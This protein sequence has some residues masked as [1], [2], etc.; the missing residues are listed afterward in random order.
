MINLLLGQPGGGKSYE[1]VAYH[2]IPAIES[3]RK[4]KTNLPLNLEYFYSVYPDSVDLIE[5]V[6]PDKAYRSFQNIRDYGDDWRHPD[7]GV[8][9]LYV[10]DECH[11]CLRRGSTSQEVEEWFSM[12]RH[13]LADVLLITQSYGKVD[14]NIIDLVQLC[15]RVKKATAFGS[16]SKY[17]RK[18]QD[19]VRGEVMNTSFRSYEKKYFPFYNS[20]TLS[21]NSASE[22]QATDI[23]AFWKQW[24][25]IIAGLCL[26]VGIPFTVNAFNNMGV[27]NDEIKVVQVE[28][29]IKKDKPIKYQSL[30]EF[31]KAQADIAKAK[32]KTSSDQKVVEEKKEEIIHHPYEK[33]RLHIKGYLKSEERDFELIQFVASQNGQP[34][35]NLTNNDVLAAGYKI[36]LVSGCLVILTFD[37][38][39][40]SITCDLPSV[41]MGLSTPMS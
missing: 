11:F 19:G 15:Y 32:A 13:E 16:D 29:P 25:I 33:L 24:P 14:K 34:V 10:I 7:S 38:Y 35:F 23:K 22:S 2:V 18:V 28:E 41:G 5:I 3:G 30:E 1:A 20:H 12:H 31:K 9:V 27:S 39:K 8:G 37:K 6:Q 21:D 4:V 36:R 26:L 17:I 40:E